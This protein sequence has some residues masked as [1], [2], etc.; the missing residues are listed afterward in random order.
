MG[1]FW[2]KTLSVRAFLRNAFHQFLHATAPIERVAD[3]FE[4][5]AIVSWNAARPHGRDLYQSTRA[6]WRS[7][8]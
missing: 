2:P 1:L 6:P 5:A 4:A 7:R 3:L 8:S